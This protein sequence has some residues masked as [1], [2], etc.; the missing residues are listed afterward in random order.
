MIGE[1]RSAS[2]AMFFLISN[3]K[4]RRSEKKS[5]DRSL[6]QIEVFV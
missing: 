5:S 2:P 1:A 6:T 3:V 4:M